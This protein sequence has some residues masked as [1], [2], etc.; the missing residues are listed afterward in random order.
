MQPNEST[1]NREAMPMARA[2]A[3]AD[4][5][6]LLALLLQFPEEKT[7]AGLADGAVSRDV[8]AIAGELDA[9]GASID[10]V[11]A[12]LGRLEADLSSGATSI[13]EARREYTRLFNHPD[14]PAVPLFEGVFIDTERLREGEPSVRPRLFVNP[15][16]LDAERCYRQAGLKRASDI[17]IPA[18]CISTELEFLAH[19]H[20]LEAQAM[21]CGD[22]EKAAR[23]VAWLEEFRRLHVSKWFRRFF[24]R[25]AEESAYDLYRAVGALG[26]VGVSCSEA[27]A[28]EQCAS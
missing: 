4:L 22:K 3:E 13:V 28:T 8:A 17:N 12:P 16:A 14:G 27:P 2:T 5:C 9:D 11:L 18:D 19:L 15:A 6:L 25:C 7:V 10:D 26:A 20:A 1:A 24:E 21:A 23:A